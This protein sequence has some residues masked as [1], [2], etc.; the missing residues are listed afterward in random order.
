MLTC[1]VTVEAHAYCWGMDQQRTSRSIQRTP[2]RIKGD[3][4]FTAITVDFYQ[5][6]ALERAG[7]V[8]CWA[9]G[10]FNK[11]MRVPAPATFKQLSRG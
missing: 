7:A 1:G 2:V 8:Y 4:R 3:H 11:P 10:I 9:D 5:A 6:C